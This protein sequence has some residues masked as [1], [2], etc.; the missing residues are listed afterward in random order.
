MRVTYWSF[1]YKGAIVI[2]YKPY[3]SLVI[4][5]VVIIHRNRRKIAIDYIC[6]RWGILNWDIISIV[7]R[8]YGCWKNVYC[9]V[10]SIVI[11]V[12]RIVNLWL[13]V[14]D[15]LAIAI[16]KSNIIHSFSCN[17]SDRCIS[18]WN[19]MVIL[20]ISYIKGNNKV[21]IYVF[22]FVVIIDHNLVDW[23][24]F[25]I[26]TIL[27]YEYL[28]LRILTLAVNNAVWDRKIANIVYFNVESRLLILRK[29]WHYIQINCFCNC[30]KVSRFAVWVWKRESARDLVN[31]RKCDTTFDSYPL[32]CGRINYNCVLSI[33]FVNYKTCSF[34]SC[35]ARLQK[36][37]CKSPSNSS[38][39]VFWWRKSYQCIFVELGSGSAHC[40]VFIRSLFF[41]F[42]THC[43]NFTIN[44]D[45]DSLWLIS[46]SGP[47]NQSTITF[48]LSS[49]SYKSPATR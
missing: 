23:I 41:L 11:A 27:S 16:C 7:K 43:R 4:D 6:H 49:D 33:I 47:Y 35:S 28:V 38:S 8:L 44:L 15:L 26:I 1:S 34:N 2:L 18:C 30:S 39:T 24:T 13:S 36:S 21:L 46:F 32:F 29:V 19:W 3:L 40:K 48:A 5:I 37:V 14:C 12:F 42:R 31:N 17:E 20:L 45:I 25:S 22:V 9:I 10:L